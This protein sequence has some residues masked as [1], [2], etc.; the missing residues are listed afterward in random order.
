[1][2]DYYTYLAGMEH[3]FPG[4]TL[5]EKWV[6]KNISDI[7]IN[8]QDHIELFLSKDMK[9]YDIALQQK[10]FGGKAKFLSG[11]RPRSI[12]Y[13][14]YPRSGNTF[15]RKYLENVTGVATGSDVQMKFTMNVELQYSGFIGE[16]HFKDKTWI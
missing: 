8:L 2:D 5:D 16:G 11:S 1:M 15:L 7:Y 6:G 13:A 4:Y 9:R 12:T 10:L 3:K 14:S